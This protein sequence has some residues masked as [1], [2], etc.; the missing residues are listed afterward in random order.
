VTSRTSTRD[1]AGF[2]VVL[3]MLLGL[4]VLLG[5][6]YAA[7]Y[8]TAQDK[9]PRG[10]RVAGVKIGGRTL[11][12]AAA[13]LRAGLD[14]RANAPITLQIDGKRSIV[15][16]SE[17]G[18]GVDYVASVR[19]AGAG[20]SWDPGRLW[21][22]Y[23]GGDRLAPVVTVS[24]MT[25]T[26]F[27][28][29][30]FARSGRPPRDGRVSFQGQ[31]VVVDQPHPGRT[32]DPQQ[33]REAITAAYLQD[34]PT[35]DLPLVATAPTIDDGDI[36]TALG[37][38]ANPAVSGGVAL[39]LGD[40]HVLLQ[41]RD[42]ASA[43]SL[44]PDNGTLVPHVDQD[45]LVALVDEAIAGHTSPVDA[46][47]AILDGQPK[48]V[49]D[50]PGVTFDPAAVTAAFMAAVVQPLGERDATVDVVLT[51]PEVTAQDVRGLQI[52]DRVS[53]FTTSYGYDADRNASIDQAMRLINGTVLRPGESFSFNRVV[54]PLGGGR[55]AVQAAT[56]TF[57]A[58]Y[59][60]GLG[61]LQRTA[62]ASHVSGYPV[63][64][65]ATVGSSDEDLTFT[66][67]TPY[68]VLVQAGVRP[69]TPTSPGVVTVTMWSTAYWQVTSSRS[70]RY[71]LVEPERVVLHTDDCEAS[72]GQRGF[73]VDATRHVHNLVDAT[74]DHDEVLHTTYAPVDTIVCKPPTGQPTTASSSTSTTQRSSSSPATTS[75]VEAGR[76]A[77]NTSPCA[78]DA[79]GSWARSVRKV[80]V[81]T[82]SPTVPPSSW[83]AP[84][85]ISQQ[86][87]A[88]VSGSGSTDP[89]GQIGAVPETK[90]C[91]PLRT[92]RLNPTDFSYGDP[93][94]TCSRT[95]PSSPMAPAGA[96][97]AGRA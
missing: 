23:T 70:A 29:G 59:L 75:I 47:V 4:V 40:L 1:R 2:G 68:G 44:R 34:D 63:G 54:G 88:W 5:G 64:L 38:F 16:P 39:E 6:G 81:R 92:A 27:V 89:S 22:Y 35:A 15:T 61:D 60:A 57:N 84:T 86:R 8:V 93:L 21:N 7:A 10:A 37:A 90:M 25:M 36:R 85:A 41:P 33:A 30:L 3:V 12:A 78:V 48:V 51:E 32:I 26:D 74:L 91:W 53:S 87:R 66:N 95:T 31:R 9:T 13:A 19:E 96:G 46:T 50:R 17:V 42:F 45:M 18:L 69:S 80:R 56:T 28:A 77:S 94:F 65:E 55:G 11:A 79:A 14:T 49:H 43:L 24:E 72:A 76:A 20:R 58:A 83:S 97:R 71:N 73:D 52:R 67:T 62:P 82:T